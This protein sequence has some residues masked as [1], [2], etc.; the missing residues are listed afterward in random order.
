M[1]VTDL[2]LLAVVA[3]AAGLTGIGVFSAPAFVAV[4]LVAIAVFEPIVG[5]PAAVTARARA[6]AASSRLTELFPDA[7]PAAAVTR[8]VDR[9]AWPIEIRLEAQDTELALMAGDTVLLT[10]ASGAG[11]STIL[12]AISGQPT[13]GVHAQLAGVDT[14]G[15]DPQALAEHVTL[16]AQDAHIFD[17]TIRDN[18]EL[19]DPAATEPQLW[20]ALAA[21][22]LDDTVAAFP[23]RL[24]TPV[25]PGGA[26]PL[27]RPTPPPERRAGA[28]PTPGH[29]AARRTHRRPRHRH[30]RTP[31]RR[32]PRVRP[33]RRARDRPP[34]PPIPKAV[35]DGDRAHRA[36]RRREDTGMVR[37]IPP[38]RR[39]TVARPRCCASLTISPSSTPGAPPS[40][41]SRWVTP[42]SRIRGI[43]CAVAEHG[44]ARGERPASPLT[45]SNRARGRRSA[46]SCRR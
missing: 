15:I 35:T 22:A 4:C 14:A 39:A 32:R 19:A 9:S 6:R 2:T 26:R 41:A 24:D 20:K 44:D 38:R 5:L 11:K 46:P 30:R 42:P 43:A 40:S 10:G 28:A 27:G 12:R 16:V 13:P 21:A 33:E 31:T 45:A 36:S 25:G 18:L 8:V 37:A 1:F 7:T 23:A 34:R 29:P 3:T 17:G